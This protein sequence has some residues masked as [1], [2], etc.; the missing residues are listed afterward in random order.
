MVNEKTD[1]TLV[2]ALLVIAMLIALTICGCFNTLDGFRRDLH[3]ITKDNVT[4]EN[5]QQP[6]H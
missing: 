3:N 4:I 5:N 2:V 6:R 1:G